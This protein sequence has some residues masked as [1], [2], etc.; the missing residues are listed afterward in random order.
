MVVWFVATA[1]LAVFFVFDS[2]AVDHRF[3]A[4]GA[5]LPLVELITGDPWLLHTLVGSVILLAVVMGI[6]I[7]RRLR[8]RQLL[9]LPIGTFMF[10]VFSGSWSRTGLFWWPLAGLD[11]LGTGTAPEIDRPLV[12][13]LLLELAGVAALAWLWRRYELGADV[14][15]HRLVSTGRLPARPGP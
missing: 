11:E 4:A 8:R 6:T 9:G 1:V 13:I 3:V 2:P 12:V 14:N 5:L 15:R 7:G 10:L